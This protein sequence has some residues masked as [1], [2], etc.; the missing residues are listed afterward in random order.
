MKIW[1]A[2]IL[3]CGFGSCVLAYDFGPVEELRLSH[4]GFF[5][6]GR[7]S[8]AT[9]GNTVYYV[10]NGVAT[11][12]F[13]QM[14]YSQ[15]RTIAKVRA[16]GTLAK[17]L[18]NGEKAYDV[19]IKGGLQIARYEGGNRIL[20]LFAVPTS[21]VSRTKCQIV[22]SPPSVAQSNVSDVVEAEMRDSQEDGSSL[23]RLSDAV[24]SHPEDGVLRSRL[25]KVYFDARMYDEAEMEARRA[26]GL[27]QEAKKEQRSDEQVEALLGCADIM[28]QIG[29]YKSA[30]N[31]YH[32][33]KDMGGSRFLPAA[34][35]GISAV[36][37]KLGL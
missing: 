20:Y 4:P 9:N 25:A 30:G 24:D 27:L 19:S 5:V 34:L 17:F 11:R 28:M 8:V 31:I 2:V 7:V 32:S 36:N 23:L 15:L 22:T 1:G 12:R 6:P 18:C 29:D 33:V 13:S 10:Y 21:G 16:E 3:F 37:L 35:Q 26:V 14:P